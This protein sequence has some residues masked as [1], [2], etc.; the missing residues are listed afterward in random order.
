MKPSK[1]LLAVIAHIRHAETGYD[2]LLAEG[3]DRR[4]ARAQVEGAV[5]RVLTEWEALE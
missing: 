2:E 4:D 1:D 5:S 3:F